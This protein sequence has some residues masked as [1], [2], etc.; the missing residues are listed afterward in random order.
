MSRTLDRRWPTDRDQ[1]WADRALWRLVVREGVPGDLAEDVLTEAHQACLETGLPAGELFG[2]PDR[3]AA[4]V[5]RERVPDGE[6][7]AVDPDGSTPHDHWPLWFLTLGWLTLL[8][9]LVL[10]AD[11]GWDLPVTAWGLAVYAAAVAFGT[12]A[13]RGRLERRAGRLRRGWAWWL[14]GGAVL[15]GALAAASPLQ[16]RPALA[17]VPTVLVPA[18]GALALVTGFRWPQRA[19][20]PHAGGTTPEQWFDDLAGLLRGRYSLTRREVAHHVQEARSHWADSGAA[21]PREE[22]GTAAE[23]ALH[24]TD[25]SPA[26]RRGR[27]RGA[28]W[29]STALAAFWCWVVAEE[30]LTG[31]AGWGL[32]WRAAGLLL[33]TAAAVRAWRAVRRLR[34]PVP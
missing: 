27:A 34:R 3:Y 14:T 11:H 8:L 6:R 28:A 31:G 12:G 10:L 15:V 17:V 33:F 32:A 30:A 19:P 22:F 24:L 13:H 21:H 9:G 18:A 25:D 16:D 7:A 26:P 29:L 1:A 4:D 23:H 20:R 2:D 5:A